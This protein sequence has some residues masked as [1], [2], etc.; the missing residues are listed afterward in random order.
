[1]IQQYLNYAASVDVSQATVLADTLTAA[2]GNGPLAPIKAV[3]LAPA[4]GLAVTV[5]GTVARLRA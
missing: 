3:L 4:T 1:M 5:L 2:F